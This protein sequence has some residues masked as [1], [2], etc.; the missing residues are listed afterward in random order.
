MKLFS[1]F[2]IAICDL[3]NKEGVMAEYRHTV[4]FEPLPEGGYQVH[5]PAMPEIITYG[6]TIEE[7]REMAE[8]AIR[9]TIQGLL[10]DGEP[11][12]QDIEPVPERLEVSLP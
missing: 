3:N 11:I 12:P 1:K 2:E 4:L 10:K 7:A 5:V 8:D 6:R 9:C